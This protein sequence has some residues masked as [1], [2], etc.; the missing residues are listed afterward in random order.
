MRAGRYGDAAKTYQGMLEQT[1]T[2]KERFDLYTKIATAQ[3]EAGLYRDAL[4]TLVPL[5]E[6]EAFIDQFPQ[7]QLQIGRTHTRAGDVKRGVFEFEGVIKEGEKENVNLEGKTTIT[8]SP[9]AKEAHY[10]LGRTQEEHYGNLGRAAG[11]YEIGSEVSLVGPDARERLAYVK[12]WQ[13]LRGAIADTSDSTGKVTFKPDGVLALAQHF[14]LNLVK[15]DSAMH[16]YQIAADSFPKSPLRHRAAYAV[17]W[18]YWKDRRDSVRADSSWQRLMVDTTRSSELGEIQEHVREMLG[19][20]TPDPALEPYRRVEQRWV[21][22]LDSLPALAPD[23]LDS[24]GTVHWWSEW[25]T[26]HRRLGTTYLDSMKQIIHRFGNSPSATRARY[27]LGWYFENV[28]ADT[29]AAFAWYRAAASDT[30]IAP[31][32]AAQAH[33]LMLDRVPPRKPVVLPDTA[34]VDTVRADSLVAP[35]TDSLTSPAPITTVPDSNAPDSIIP[36]KTRIRSMLDSLLEDRVRRRRRYS[37]PDT[38]KTP[39]P[40]MKEG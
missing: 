2:N 18:I 16:Y 24:T 3:R 14:Y 19:R 9:E 32:I 8:R 28:E 20:T 21:S 6:N 23:S 36:K 30:L 29:A 31:E 37:K 4:N 12:T 7:I 34:G 15:I 10:W 17:G 5:L 35:A 11:H 1:R 26:Q 38:T 39:P 25:R 13:K 22:A 27:V 40:T 33:T